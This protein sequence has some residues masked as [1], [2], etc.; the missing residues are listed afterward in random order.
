MD[1]GTGKVTP[2]EMGDIPHYMIDI[3]SPEI[4]FSVVEF[5]EMARKILADIHAR[6]KIPI[7]CGGTG[8]YLDSL[9]L[10]RSYARNEPDWTRRN[11][12]KELS[13]KRGNT[14]IWEM[15]RA[16][17]PESAMKIHKNNIHGVIRAIEVFES[18]GRSKTEIQDV[19]ELLFPTF[20]VTPYDGNREKLYTKIDT[21]VG[22]MFRE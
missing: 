16:I 20:F 6:G 17:D 11:E 2:E 4:A 3:L 15:L 13:E 1:I 22:E 21:R 9:I 18:T 10:R 5:Q 12:L 7:L 19:P 8:L 14:E